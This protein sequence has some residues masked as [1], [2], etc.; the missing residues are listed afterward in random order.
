MFASHVSFKDPN[1]CMPPDILGIHPSN[2]SYACATGIARFSF[3]LNCDHNNSLLWQELIFYFPIGVNKSKPL[4]EA[5][6]D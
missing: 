2:F 5:Y 1:A 4:Q 3:P 6:F